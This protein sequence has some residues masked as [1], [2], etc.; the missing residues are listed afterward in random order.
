MNS[1]HITLAEKHG[2]KQVLYTSS[3]TM[4]IDGKIYSAQ[5]VSDVETLFEQSKGK[6]L[7]IYEGRMN[8]TGKNQTDKMA[9]G[10]FIT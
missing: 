1:K 8:Y 3:N 10:G 5:M 7:T 9:V 4:R 2:V 6:T